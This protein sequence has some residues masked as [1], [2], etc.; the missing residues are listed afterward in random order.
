MIRSKHVTCQTQWRQYYGMGMY[1]E[2]LSGDM[3]ADRG[4]IMRST[5]Q[6]SAHIQASATDLHRA[7]R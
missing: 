7:H 1:A 4:L 5:E 6:N 3:T 2:R